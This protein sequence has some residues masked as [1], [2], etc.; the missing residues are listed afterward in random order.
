MSS[1]NISTSDPQ[2]PMNPENVN[3]ITLQ[4]SKIHLF[5]LTGPTKETFTTKMTF[6]R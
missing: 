1:M 2:A 5:F 6:L 4:N 3:N